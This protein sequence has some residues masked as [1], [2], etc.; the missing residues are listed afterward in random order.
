MLLSTLFAGE[1][2]NATVLMLGAKLRGLREVVE[3]K[4]TKHRKRLQTCASWAETMATPW[5]ASNSATDLPTHLPSLPTYLPTDLPICLL[6]TSPCLLVPICVR[7][8][9]HT[10]S[11]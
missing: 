4:M 3:A 1:R 8:C 9:V 6:P 2:S 5:L 11:Y 7:T 10:E